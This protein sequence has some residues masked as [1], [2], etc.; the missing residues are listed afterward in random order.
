MSVL[1]PQYR[2]AMISG[3]MLNYEVGEDQWEDTGFMTKDGIFAPCKPPLRLTQFHSRVVSLVERH[4]PY[5]QAVHRDEVGLAT[6]AVFGDRSDAPEAEGHQCAVDG[7]RRGRLARKHQAH[8]Q[9]AA[10]PTYMWKCLAMSSPD[11]M[12]CDRTKSMLLMMKLSFLNVVVATASSTSLKSSV[13]DAQLGD[14]VMYGQGVY[15]FT[16]YFN[17]LSVSKLRTYTSMRSAMNHRR[18][19]SAAGR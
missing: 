2:E 18:R 15:D 4:V 3:A 12:I 16:T 5:T 13:F 14:W 19:I 7:R 6:A 9:P 8:L 10:H 11:S 17:A 1:K